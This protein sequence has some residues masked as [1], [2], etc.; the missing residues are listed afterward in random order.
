[1]V[2]RSSAKAEFRLVAHRICEVLW[3]KRILDELKVSSSSPIKAYCDNKA[4]ISIAHN[5]ILQDK[6]NHV[7]VNKHFIREK[8]ENG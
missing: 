8:I 7:E 1:M 4:V 2:A 6:T 5:P 3:I